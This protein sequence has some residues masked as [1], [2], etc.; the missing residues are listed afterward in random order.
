[1]PLPSP[2]IDDRTFQQL[3]TELKARIPVYNPEWTD[4]NESDPAITLLELMAFHGEA[5]LYRLNQVPEATYLEYL[6]LLQVPL[7]AAPG[8]ARPAGAVDRGDAGRAGAAA[9]RGRGRQAGV[10]DADRGDRLAGFRRGHGQG[11][12][13]AAGARRRVRSARVRAADGRRAA[14]FAGR[15]AAHLLRD[16]RSRSGRP[17][18]AARCAAPPS[19]A[20]CG[21]RCWPRRASTSTDWVRPGHPPVL[22]NVGLAPDL[23]AAASTPSTPV[24]GRTSGRSRRQLDWQIST[25]RPL[26]PGPARLHRAEG[27]G[28]HHPRPAARRRRAAAPAGWRTTSACRRGTRTSPARATTRR[29]GWT[30][31]PSSLSAGSAPSGATAATSASSGWWRCNAVESEN[32]RVAGAGVPRLG[33]GQPSQVFALA[34]Q[35]VLPDDDRHQ[36]IVEVEEGGQSGSGGNWVRYTRVDDFFGSTREV[37]PRDDRPRVRR[38]CASATACAGGCRSS[39]SASG[40]AATATAAALRATSRAKAIAKIRVEGVKVDNPLPAARRRRRRERS[41]TRCCASRASSAGATGP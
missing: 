8:G 34:N 15:P 16:A 23:P 25:P 19:T 40:R 27:R 3:S 6:R 28:R 1:M 24:R 14:A 21:S 9:E 17:V 2:I 18:P 5:L 32:A 10:P 39:A 37:S 31:A 4:H 20:C 26:P 30:I 38:W 7:Q 36:L 13:R 41:R 35:P 12:G 11:V 22:L 33:D 29:S